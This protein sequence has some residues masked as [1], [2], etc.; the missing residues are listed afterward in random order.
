[1]GWEAWPLGNAVSNSNE[2]EL[3]TII[4]FLYDNVGKPTASYQHTWNGCGIHVTESDVEVGRAEY[5]DR[6]NGLLER[7]ERPYTLRVD[8]EIWELAP[9]GLEPIEPVVLGEPAIDDRIG[10]AQASFR[11]FGAT[12]DDKRH[13]VRDLADVL[14]HLR[15]T[16]QL[17]LPN[18]DEARLFE[19]AN[20]YGIR[21]H[22]PEQHDQYDSGIWLEWIYYAYLN[23][24]ATVTRL[25]ARGRN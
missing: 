25:I 18:A 11:R 16:G 20:Q 14:E 13:A 23:T 9:D 17:Q 8:G 7:Y 1:L 3:F 4:E 15:E 19:I 5:R 2:E 10:A 21:H 6:I 24:I 12:E 22:N